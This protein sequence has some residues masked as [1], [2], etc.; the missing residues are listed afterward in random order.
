MIKT[1]ICQNEIT[2]PTRQTSG[3]YSA[4]E[5]KL[6]LRIWG[7]SMETLDIEK[8]LGQ[9]YSKQVDLADIDLRH[10]V[11]L[12]ERDPFSPVQR[13][14]D[15]TLK[16]IEYLASKKP[17]LLC[18]ETASAL[19]ILC[20]PVLVSIAQN[21]LVIFRL[22]ISNSKKKNQECKQAANAL[23]AV[24]IPTIIETRRQSS[25]QAVYEIINE[26]MNLSVEFADA[27]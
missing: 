9:L 6:R 5:T 27:A 16:T 17:K 3:Y 18:I 11:V 8:N 4:E 19:A 26:Q 24:G 2:K 14:L 12:L 7:T 23:K 25:S 10:S 22:D 1:K 15:I 20:V 13:K 21:S